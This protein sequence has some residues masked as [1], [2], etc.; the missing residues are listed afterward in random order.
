MQKW[1]TEVSSGHL[2]DNEVVGPVEHVEEVRP[3]ALL[4]ASCVLTERL[5]ATRVLLTHVK[6]RRAIESHLNLKRAD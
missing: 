3:H 4:A 1:E 2:V 5:G 6:Y